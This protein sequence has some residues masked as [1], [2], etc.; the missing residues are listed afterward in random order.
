MTRVFFVLSGAIFFGGC[1]PNLDSDMATSEDVNVYEA[2]QSDVAGC[3]F[4]VDSNY[5]GAA[6]WMPRDT[7]IANLHSRHMGDKISSVRLRGGAT[8]KMWIDTNYGGRHWDI[9][10]DVTTLHTAAWGNLG[11]N[12]SS[13]DCY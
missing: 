12:A 10:S 5:G 11:D 2:S 9:S 8:A 7:T 13:V 4:Y 6:L 3:H 1:A